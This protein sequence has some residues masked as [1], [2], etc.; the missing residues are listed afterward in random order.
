MDQAVADKTISAPDAWDRYYQANVDLAP[1]LGTP[2]VSAAFGDTV[3]AAEGSFVQSAQRGFFLRAEEGVRSDPVEV[4]SALAG[5]PDSGAFGTLSGSRRR[6]ARQT[7]TGTHV[8]VEQLVRGAR[9]IGSD[10][11]VHH[12]ERG[13][14]AVTGRPL[15]DIS[16][17]DPGPAPEVDAQDALDTCAERFELED[18][19][20]SASVEQVVFPEGDGAIWA[21]E[22]AFVVPEDAADVRTFLRADDMSVILSYNISSAATGQAQVYPVNPLQN[23]EVVEV[24]LE[25][26]EDSGSLLRGHAI[27]VQQAAGTRLDR[28][29]GDF[30]VDPGDPA[31][32][33]AQAYHHLW[34]AI[35]YFRGIVD[36]ALLRARPFTPMT[37][38]V[39]DRFS[40]NN[41]YY[42]P[43]TAQLRFGA[44]FG[45]RSSARSA[46]IVIHEFG[47]AVTDAICHLGRGKIKNSESRGLSEGYSDYFAASLLDDPR[48]GD[49]V[50]DD[51]HGARNCSNPALRFP[52]GFQGEEHATGSVWA[53][54]LWA[55]RQQVGQAT[56]DKLAIESVDFLDSS[57]TFED[58]RS[59]LHSVDA[60][61]FDTANK[62]LIDQEFDARAPA[63]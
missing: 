42:T 6:G 62:E 17:R 40:P 7:E 10:V 49:Y 37:A 47:H 45:T 36:A 46:A 38:L 5:V 8:Q 63:Q 2:G 54:V 39:N 11:R 50:A 20:R 31:F 56:A 13:V 28:P 53:A 12:D 4:F 51:P 27:D 52:D 16:A 3:E 25:G 18:R 23:A 29:G 32:D 14:Y 59:A 58:A 48:L 19:M 24:T 60:K 15:G 26:L 41:A 22:V 33:E 21:Y 55:I 1:V 43:T 57:S 9:V 35:E 30:R 61:L 44:F 34:R